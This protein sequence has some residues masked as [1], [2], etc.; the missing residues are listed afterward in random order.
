MPTQRAEQFVELLARGPLNHTV[1]LFESCFRLGESG[2]VGLV[3]DRVPES[4]KVHVGEAC[5]NSVRR[6][7]V[8]FVKWARR[9]AKDS[10]DA[11]GRTA[12]VA[13]DHELGLIEILFQ[14]DAADADAADRFHAAVLDEARNEIEGFVDFG[15][16]LGAEVGQGE[17]WV[18]PAVDTTREAFEPLARTK[19]SVKAAARI[20]LG[21]D[22]G[23]AGLFRRDDRRF[24][25]R[26][27]GGVLRF[28]LAASVAHGQK[29]QSRGDHQSR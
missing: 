27:R 13:A 26:R 7:P 22:L 20:E 6:E 9:A 21:G 2:L 17:D 15:F 8:Q 24:A 4:A 10:P 25:L 5:P 11:A 29:Q 23:E 19:V 12:G 28:F 1:Q 18:A 16:F 3:D 14:R